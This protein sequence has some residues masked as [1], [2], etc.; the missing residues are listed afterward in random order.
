VEHR[1]SRFVHAASMS[2]LSFA[3]AEVLALKDFK[4]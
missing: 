4:P 1:T 2:A 3:Y